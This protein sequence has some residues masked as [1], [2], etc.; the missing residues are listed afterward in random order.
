MHEDSAEGDSRELKK[1]KGQERVNAT[2]KASFM[3][4]SH[5]HRLLNIVKAATDPA[6]HPEQSVLFVLKENEALKKVRSR[7]QIRTQ[8]S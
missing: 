3:T 8:V 6:G 1:G 4:A 7:V 2:S 5:F